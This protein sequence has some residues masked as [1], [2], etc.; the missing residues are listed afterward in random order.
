MGK[1][2]INALLSQ[3]DI[4]ETNGALKIPSG[5]LAP[6][7]ITTA[8]SIGYVRNVSSIVYEDPKKHEGLF[9]AFKVPFC[10]LGLDSYENARI[11]V[12]N[13]YSPM[14]MLETPEDVDRAT[15]ETARCIRQHVE[16][17]PG[18]SKL[19]DVVGELHDNVR[20]HANGAGFSM[21]L[22]WRHLGGPEDVI[23]FAITDTGQ[24]FLRECR[25]RGVPG[26]DDHQSALD[27]CMR[28]RNSTKDRDHDEFSQQIAEDAIGNP[29]EGAAPTHP[30][31]DGNHHQGL[32][33]AHLMDLVKSYQGE[34]WV[35]SGNK[36]LISN[37]TTRAGTEFGSY[38]E[39]PYW[40]GVAIACK[41]KISALGQN[42]EE[43]PLS[44]D[45][46]N[47]LNDLLG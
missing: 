39:I 17:L 22:I 41:L 4:A 2:I 15:T 45:V 44:Q 23:E 11:N 47:L 1:G 38:R 14:Q 8:T 42:V 34:L 36:V 9:E 40:Q 27:W 21:A 24:G 7:F 3:E 33:L 5:F 25:R 29:F 10:L 46:Q 12:G 20:A 35:A 16:P 37:S 19:C 30:R 6:G 43:E 28:P 32:G 31:H 18:V 26:V 13:R